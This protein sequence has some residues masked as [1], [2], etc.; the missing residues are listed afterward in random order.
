MGKAPTCVAPTAEARYPA[1]CD[2]SRNFMDTPYEQILILGTID[3]A[4]MV[5][6]CRSQ[7]MDA[8]KFGGW[9]QRY[10]DG[11][12]WCARFTRE[13]TQSE[14][15]SAGR[16]SCACYPGPSGHCGA[17]CGTSFNT[18]TPTPAPT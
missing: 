18:P 9:S 7:Y 3:F 2:A 4:D 17:V 5:S 15:D 13:P 10:S 11:G 8:G 6:K 16:S 14:W 1:D 12:G